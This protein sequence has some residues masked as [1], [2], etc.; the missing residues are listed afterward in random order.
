M[1][2]IG[3]D[4]GTTSIKGAVL[5][6]DARALGAV[7]RRPFPS[8]IPDLPRCH[9]EVDPGTMLWA[10]RAVLDELLEEA[11]D[12]AGVLLCSQMHGVVLL[13]D[14]LQP[15]SNVI[16]WQDQRALTGVD[17]QAP[18]FELLRAA[19]S[20]EDLQ[21]L[22]NDVWA[23]RPLAV[24]HW[25]RLHDR[26]PAGA[27]F[28]A[29]P[30]FVSSSLCHAPPMTDVGH[31]AASAMFDLARGAWDRD[32]L[33]RLG[34]NDLQLP[35]VVARDAA[36]GNVERA[37]REIPWYPP[38]ADQQCSLLGAHLEPGELS[39]NISTG[40]QV[41]MLSSTPIFG[42]YQ[43]RPFFDGNYLRTLIHVPA[44][45][46]LNALMRLLTE[47]PA[48]EGLQL[49]HTWANV[50]RLARS[51]V[52]TDLHID[53]SFFAGAFGNEG[54]LTHVRE[55]NLSVGH[56]FRAAYAAMAENYMQCA[57]RLSPEHAWRRLVFSGGL[58]LQSPLLRELILARFNCAYRL[59]EGGE[60]ALVGLLAVALTIA[61]RAPGVIAAREL[62]GK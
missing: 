35:R 5:D 1:R 44:G 58:A 42:P 54:S 61:G 7:A 51:V 11:P 2:F 16:T 38:V 8:P 27:M 24:L 29:L 31:A 21:R 40:S 49:E 46:S 43:T 45:R 41:A 15:L 13:D 14:A 62:I 55:D 34:L 60:D 57:T 32:L 28:C 53:L 10:A 17:G 3:I 48:E 6:L 52:S 39:I 37:G 12:A 26:L 20:A 25:L 33:R 47:L 36:I 22:G 23:S 50:E 59:A 9:H 30:D 4:L 19:L 56:V 18:S